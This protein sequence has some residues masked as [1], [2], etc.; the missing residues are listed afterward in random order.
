MANDSSSL[1]PNDK[2]LWVHHLLQELLLEEE[3]EAP[4]KPRL[5]AL[6][7]DRSSPVASPAPRPD[8]TSRSQQD[9][10]LALVLVQRFC[11]TQRP[12]DPTP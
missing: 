6:L 4:S 1:L 3:E 11:R 5:Q 7:R 9:S 10:R 2:Y 12:T 8:P